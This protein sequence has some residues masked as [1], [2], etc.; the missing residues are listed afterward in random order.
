LNFTLQVW[1]NPGRANHTH[2]HS[3]KFYNEEGLQTITM[4]INKILLSG[5]LIGLGFAATAQNNSKVSFGLRGGFDYQNI[6]GKNQ[7]G[8]KLT[9]DMVPRFNVGLVLEIPLAD[10]FFIQPAILYTT[11]G[12]EAKNDYLGLPMSTEFNIGYLELP[13]NLVYKPT[14]GSGNLM[15]GFGPYIAY[16]IG[17]DVEY[18]VDGNSTKEKIE[19]TDTYTNANPFDAKYLKP[20]DY[21]GNILFG[22]Q[23][24]GGLSAQLNAQLGLAEMRAKNSV[25][26]NNKASFKNTGFGISLGYMF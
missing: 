18:T 13:V 21:G 8:D 5:F 11:K 2:P 16:G 14:L 7:N 26:A 23:F 4:S 24:A 6:N 20:L 15:I 25:Y 19:F 3:S 1:N 9:F 10:Q 22:Y 17:G 12:A